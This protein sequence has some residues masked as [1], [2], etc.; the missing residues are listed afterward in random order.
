MRRDFKRQSRRAR[1]QSRARAEEV[2][3]A[4]DLTY[5]LDPKIETTYHL[6]KPGDERGAVLRMGSPSFRRVFFRSVLSHWM[7]LCAKGSTNLP[8]G[9]CIRPPRRTFFD[10]REGF[11]GETATRVTPRGRELVIEEVPDNPFDVEPFVRW[12]DSFPEGARLVVLSREELELRA[13][14]PL[15]EDAIGA[16]TILFEL[17]RKT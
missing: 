9:A 4:L 8:Q 7:S 14:E 2:A 10:W 1:E 16:A 15:T 5:A 6:H 11:P 17:L 3:R 13:N 12:I